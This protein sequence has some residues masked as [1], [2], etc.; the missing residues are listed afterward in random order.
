MLPWD[1]GFILE[2]LA[3][4]SSGLYYY[5][6]PIPQEADYGIYE[7]E[8]EYIIVSGA[9]ITRLDDHVEVIPILNPSAVI[10]TE[11]SVSGLCRVY[12]YFSVGNSGPTQN[13]I[14]RASIVNLP[15]DYNSALFV[16]YD[17]AVEY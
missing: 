16:N 6:L 5:D 13:A 9:D 14:A 3:R 11:A 10:P 12:D 1:N 15:Y 2:K 4:V 8:L 17:E 7:A